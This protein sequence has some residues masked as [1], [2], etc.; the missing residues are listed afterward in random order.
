TGARFAADGQSVFYSASSAGNLPDLYMTRVESPGRT[1]RLQNYGIWSISSSGQMALAKECE[2]NWG[3]CIGTLALAPI[4]SGEPKEILAHV[5]AA[6]FYPDG[7]SLAVAQF[8]KGRDSLLQYTLKEG[9]D[10]A[11]LRVIYE[12]PSGWVGNIRVS[13]RGDLIAFF[14]HP[15]LGQIGG[16]VAVLDLAG[17]KKTLSTGWTTLDG[18]VWS[19]K[20]D[21]IWFAGSRITASI[22]SLHGV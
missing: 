16:S 6:D 15:V 5:H 10:T 4:L 11:E 19:P 21:E 17:N 8:A 2:L 13:P 22:T 3:R 12:P 9:R 7:K 18:L 14:D 1:V 20:G